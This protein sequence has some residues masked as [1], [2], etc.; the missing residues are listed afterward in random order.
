MS[1]MYAILLG[2]SCPKTLIFTGHDMNTLQKLPFFF[3]SPNEHLSVFL[4]ENVLSVI[5]FFFLKSS[6][7]LLVSFQVEK[8]HLMIV[9]ASNIYLVLYLISY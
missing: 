6:D 3:F 1:I 9:T 8:S 7:E 2:K 5:D 4:G